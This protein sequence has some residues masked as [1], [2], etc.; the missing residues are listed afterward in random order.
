MDRDV[1]APQS[2]A[3]HTFPRKLRPLRSGFAREHC[4]AGEPLCLNST[5]SRARIDADELHM[6]LSRG[7][8]LLV[9]AG[10]ILLLSLGHFGTEGEGRRY[11]EVARWPVTEAVVR[12]AAAGWTSYSWSGKKNRYCPEVTYSYSVVARH[13]SG[14]NRVF[15]FTCW[16]DAYDF[17]AQHRPGSSLQIAYDPTDPNVS[18]IPSSVR[19]PGYPVADAVGGCFF[20]L[21]LLADVFASWTRE[22]PT[23]GDDF[24]VR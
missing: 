11:D 13:Y 1:A 12:S 23:A 17:V 14:Y 9:S 7:S 6:T 21:C 8:A 15:D 20:V 10:C 16:P 5:T 19:G 2:A 18:I 4:K 22:A 24:P 3:R